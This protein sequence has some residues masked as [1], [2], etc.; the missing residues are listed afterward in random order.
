MAAIA[1]QCGIL[2]DE[3]CRECQEGKR[4]AEEI[5]REITDTL[6]FKEE[7]LPLHGKFWKEISQL[8]KECCRLRNLGDGAIENYKSSLKNKTTELRKKQHT[9]YCTRSMNNFLDGISTSQIERSYFLK[10]MRINLDNLSR[11]SL[12]DLRLRYKELCENSPEKKE[13]IADLDR[14][15]SACS[16]GIEHFL[17]ELGQLY[18]SVCSFAENSSKRKRM[19]NLPRLCA[20]LML[21]GFPAELVDGDA[22][23]IPM[24]WISAVL[25]ELHQLVGSKSKT[26][27][28]TVLGVQSS[29]KSTLLNTMFGV[30]FAVNTGRCTRGAF[31]MLLKVNKDL[32]AELKCDLVM[33]IDT[34]GLKAPELAQLEDSYEHDNE[35][36]TLVIG[37]SDV[38]IIN[39]AMEN[40]PEIRD[41]LQIVV[42]A[43]IRMKEVGKRPVCHFVHQNVC[44]M[45]AYDNNMRH[46][47][48][49]LEQLNEMTVAAAKME[50]KENITKFTDVMDYHPDKSSCYIPGLWQGTP[51]MAPVNAGYSD[52]VYEFK[53]T[54]IEDLKNC[55]RTDDLT[56]FSK[57]TQSLWKAVKYEK[58]IFSF[59]NSL[60]A[61]SYAKLNTAYNCWEWAFQK[62]I[63]EW[64]II[65]ENTISNFGID[66]KNSA[67][68]LNQL[69]NTLLL[70]GSKEIS[71]GVGEIQA[72]LKQFFEK[73][74][75][76]TNLVEK[77]KEDFICS[78]KTLIRETENAMR[79]KLQ[80]SVE[81]KEGMIQVDKVQSSQTTS[82]EKRGVKNT[83][84]MLPLFTALRVFMV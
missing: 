28:V 49:L 67:T 68:T 4:R 61:E 75:G 63:Y 15:M 19:E 35:L 18:E 33:V 14:Q 54:L 83:A 5:T 11:E 55:N 24:K 48:K 51:P 37:L 12:T 29:G 10:W 38:T 84:N 40:S 77:Y 30:Q 34:E 47:N 78:A 32:K 53:K 43:F 8:E 60:V 56:H 21:D 74:D 45:S 66:D 22:S 16:L 80:G 69:L 76:S 59:R 13:H 52:T 7:Q 26:R 58:F 2:V 62:K 64:I 1:R 82:M 20:Q 39:I 73:K 70:D 81:I 3:D 27:V 42:H 71:K 72:N 79:N 31:M 17:R 6:K 25:T 50:K 36:A 65:A 57:W 44:D 23:N 9:F 46:R 41:I